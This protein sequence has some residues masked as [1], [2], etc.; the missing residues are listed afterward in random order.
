MMKK[1]SMPCRFSGCPKTQIN[2][3]GYCSKH[4][5]FR[6]KY[7]TFYEKAVDEFRE[8]RNTP[9]NFYRTRRWLKFRDWYRAKHPLCEICLSEGRGPTPMK[10]VHHIIEIEDGGDK[11][12]EANVQS[13]CAECHNREHG[14]RKKK[15]KTNR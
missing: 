12:S 11:F 9:K 14:E 15:A 7:D 1:P 5:K 10:I 3:S 2:N 6:R 4:Q 13:V 8:K